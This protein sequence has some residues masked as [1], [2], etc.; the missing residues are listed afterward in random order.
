MRQE[1]IR[2]ES[3]QEAREACPWAI[4]IIPV[5]GG[6]GYLCFESGADFQAWEQSH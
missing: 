1:L 4:I 5:D 6:G 2:C 3:E